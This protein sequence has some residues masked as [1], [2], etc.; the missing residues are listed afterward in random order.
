MKELESY[1]SQFFGLKGDDLLSIAPFFKQTTF[2]KGEYYLKPGEIC[3]S[4]SFQTSGYVRFYLDD[5][6]KEITQWISSKG[7]FIADLRGIIFKQPSKSYVQALTDCTLYTINND[8]Y[9]KIGIL[10]PAW[11]QLEKLFIANCFV[12]IEDRIFSLLSMNS[13]ER[14]NWLFNHNPELFNNVP[15]Q[16]LASMMSMTPETLSRIRRKQT[17]I[18]N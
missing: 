2:K 14:Y 15:L 16:Y 12:F 7:G 6:E 8:D 4:L 9:A 11:H 10:I 1:I 18:A 13:E 17:E 5:G 3:S